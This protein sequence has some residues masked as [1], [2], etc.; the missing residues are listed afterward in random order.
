LA[1]LSSIICLF[2][3]KQNAFLLKKIN[4]SLR[5]GG[6]VV[7]WDMILDESKTAP[8]T[9]AIFAVNMLL[10]TQNGRS[11]SFPE[12]KALFQAAGFKDICRTPIMPSQLLIA[13]K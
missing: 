11:Y 5:L 6:R 9:A 12:V 4:H 10:N 1:L 2:G 3:K 13:R 7:V 8:A